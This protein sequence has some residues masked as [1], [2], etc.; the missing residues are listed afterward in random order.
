MVANT[1]IR[2]KVHSNTRSVATRLLQELLA[3][4]VNWDIHYQ[5]LPIAFLEV[6]SGYTY[7]IDGIKIDTRWNQN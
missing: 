2:C 3:K 1:V 4:V 7:S 6:W 5:C